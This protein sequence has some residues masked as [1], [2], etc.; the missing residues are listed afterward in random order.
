MNQNAKE[1]SWSQNKHIKTMDE[2]TDHKKITFIYSYYKE[3]KRRF[4]LENFLK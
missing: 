4:R 1:L 2:E 3:D